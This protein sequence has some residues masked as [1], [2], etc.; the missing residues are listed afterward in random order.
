MEGPRQK[1]MSIEPPRNLKKSNQNQKPPWALVM[2]WLGRQ[3]NTLPVIAT[4]LG[5]SIPSPVVVESAESAE[6]I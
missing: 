4:F 6:F 3:K 2:Y 1:R 5:K